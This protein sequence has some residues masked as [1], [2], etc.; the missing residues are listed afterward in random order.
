MVDPVHAG[1]WG[2]VHAGG[3]AI[4]SGDAARLGLPRATSD[5]M[6]IGRDAQDPGLVSALDDQ[7]GQTILT[8]WIADRSGLA[9]RLGLPADA[10][11]AAVARA[12][13]A[14]F[15]QDTPAEMLGE[16]SL[17]HS[18]PSG[19]VWL[20]NAAT[21]RDR[22]F[23][24]AKGARLAFAPD[25]A[26]LRCLDW[27][28]GDL[29]PEVVGLSLGRHALRQLT[30]VRSI[31]RGIEKIPPGGSIKLAPD[32]SV[33]RGSAKL[34]VPQPRFSGDAGDAL[35]ALEATLRTVLRERLGVTGRAAMLLS[36][37][38]DSS[39]LAALA[40]Q[41]LDGPPLAICSVA[42]SGSGIADE[43]AY[44]KAVA[45]RHGIQ[46]EPVCPGP[47]A[48]PYRPAP[49][50]LSGAEIPLLSNRHCLTSCF[51]DTARS[52]GATMLV[53]GT[54]GEMSVTARLP[55]PPTVR[56][57]LGA[58][59]RLLAAKLRS[60][61]D[62]FHVALAPHRL[63]AL[64]QHRAQTASTGGAI[65]L[66]PDKSGYIPGSE[67]A[68]AQPN[69]FYAGA[70]RMDFPFR[71]LRLLRLYASLPREI[72]YALGPDRGPARAIGKDL[73]PESVLLRQ[74][75]MPADPGHHA[76]L[77]AFAGPARSRI[78][79]FRA[80]GIDD[81]L[82]LDWLDRALARVSNRGVTD[83][84]DANRVQLTALAAEYLAL[85]RAGTL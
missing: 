82:D 49:L 6:A 23:F 53:N 19:Q 12:A 24:A 39:L 48:D 9:A 61:H 2:L 43:F 22:L 67:K 73:L 30:G 13:L 80:A 8:G 45:D 65:W 25:A 56:Q 71:D 62:D 26:A 47:E 10:Q 28:D 75:G 35:A 59:R 52:L 60:E 33:Q 4:A 55:Q 15:G 81:W 7:N 76:R 17:Y 1:L 16:W 18:E 79:A 32:G 78:A 74:R 21:A 84:A 40:A 41:E 36:G 72:A 5:R 58:I 3:G 37:G 34:L 54:Y 69:A 20:M 83:L 46:I 14:R 70:L 29:D 38:L 77:Q 57:R 51:Q 42:P 66:G 44:A 85:V 63:A 27:V 50:V 31:F 68:L 11:P 64:A